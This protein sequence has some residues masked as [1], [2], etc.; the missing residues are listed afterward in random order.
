LE[1]KDTISI[2]VFYRATGLPLFCVHL[3][4][5]QSRSSGNKFGRVE[6]K[7]IGLSVHETNCAIS[8][9]FV[10]A[11]VGIP[12]LRAGKALSDIGEVQDLCLRFVFDVS[13]CDAI[14]WTWA[15]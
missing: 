2:A 14:D 6:G 13:R 7:G 1:I 10:P 4:P 5:V 15:I 8:V 9:I 3:D 12:G 11:T